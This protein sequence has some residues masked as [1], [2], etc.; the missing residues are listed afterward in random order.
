M[1]AIIYFNFSV[2]FA[3][4]YKNTCHQVCSFSKHVWDPVVRRARNWPDKAA[5][6]QLTK[7]EI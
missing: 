7:G 1:G 5:Q 4:N 3:T 2:Y 6:A